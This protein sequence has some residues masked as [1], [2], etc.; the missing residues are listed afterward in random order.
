MGL[1][2]LPRRACW[3]AF[4]GPWAQTTE[5]GLAPWPP[6]PH[7][8]TSRARFARGKGLSPAQSCT[9]ELTHAGAQGPDSQ[10]AP[11]HRHGRSRAAPL[12]WTLTDSTPARA[13]G[14]KSTL[15]WGLRGCVGLGTQCLGAKVSSRALTCA[16]VSVTSPV[17]TLC[18]NAN[19]KEANTPTCSCEEGSDPDVP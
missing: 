13:L 8:T 7:R 9:Q 2:L 19:L 18:T 6:R 11:L 1:C 10:A 15:A 4:R 3:P 17:T 12:H 14:S 5:A 16:R